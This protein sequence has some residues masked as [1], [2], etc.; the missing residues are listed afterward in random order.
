MRKLIWSVGM[1]PINVIV[2]ITNYVMLATG[3][4]THA[5]DESHVSNGIR[6]RTAREGEQLELLDGHKLTLSTTDLLICDGEDKAIGLAGIMG[7]ARDS[8]LPETKISFLRSRTSRRSVCAGLHLAIT[9]ARRLPFAL[10]KRSI[11]SAAIS[12]WG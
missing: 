6:V 10:K 3:Q 5:F 1:R 2:D 7:G 4:P 12:R 8:I 11:R 9:F